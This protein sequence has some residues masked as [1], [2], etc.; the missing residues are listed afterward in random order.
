[1]NIAE[2]KEIVG[3]IE[4][5]SIDILK[6]EKGDFKLFFQKQGAGNASI[7]IE[8]KDEKQQ[9]APIEAAEL[10]VI[11]EDSLHIIKAP[12]I[13]TFYARPNPEA[14]PFVGVGS[15]VTE[16]EPVCILEAM[17]L[18]NE[19]AAGVKGEIIEILVEDGQV[20]EYGQPLFTVKVSE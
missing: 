15:T 18:L 19:V 12:M 1:M 11:Q 17:K 5:S 8:N 9:H 14:E 2:L 3:I 13:G 6:L 4:K 20:V 10:P 7:S 16:S